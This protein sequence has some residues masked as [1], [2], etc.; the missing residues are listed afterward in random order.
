MDGALEVWCQNP[1]LTMA[2][3]DNK[4]ISFERKASIVEIHARSAS[5]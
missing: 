3:K 1:I 4:E 2:V 5:L